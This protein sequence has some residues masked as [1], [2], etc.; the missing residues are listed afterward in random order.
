MSSVIMPAVSLVEP[1]VGI[2]PVI[3]V[4]RSTVIQMV[5]QKQ[6]QTTATKSLGQKHSY[7][8]Q[9]LGYKHPLEHKWVLYYCKQYK[10]K[11]WEDCMCKV[12]E[13]DTIEDFWA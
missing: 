3:F 12:E 8:N 11:K 10:N 6:E 13:F 2:S 1:P 4:P 5:Q 7:I 9:L